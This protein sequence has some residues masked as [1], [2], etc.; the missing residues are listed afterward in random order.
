M[1]YIVY[2]SQAR[3]PMSLT[4]LQEL[5]DHSRERNDQD[6][7]TGLLVYRYNP[8]FDRGNFIQVLEG[9]QGALDDVWGRIS[10]DQR[11]HTIVTLHE[12]DAPERMFKTWSMGF[13]NIDAS[14]LSV[15]PGYAD[16]GSDA[17]WDR[18]D[19]EAL[20]APLEFLQSFYIAA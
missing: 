18:V 13:K 9:R 11:H 15:H 1:N 12:G 3:R 19:R 7:I 2:V 6:G 17:F 4:G 8:D 10:Q 14:E 5:L 16:M 20:P